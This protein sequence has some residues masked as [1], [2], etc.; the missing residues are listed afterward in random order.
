MTKG[1][2]IQRL[3]QT[4]PGELAHESFAP[5][6][7]QF[8]QQAESIRK[9]AAVGIHLYPHEGEWHFFLIERS[10]Y[11]GKHS[12][13]MAFPGGK[14]DATDLHLEHTARRES[15]EELAIPSNSGDKI[16]ELSV[17]WIP[18]SSF[19]VSPFVF[20]HDQ[21]PP[22]SINEYEVAQCYE[23]N[24]KDLLSDDSVSKTTIKVSEHVQMTDIPCFILNEKVVWGATALILA[25]LKMIFVSD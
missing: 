7:K 4:L 11:D 18:V 9:K 25:E 10:T 1:E 20:V 22:I 23:I 19:E 24:L 6:R 5:Y 13:Q 8:E 16:T 17:V 2:L 3:Q 15:E 12:A 21:R 14:P